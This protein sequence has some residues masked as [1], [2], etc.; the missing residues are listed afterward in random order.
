[1]HL[2][3]CVALVTGASAGI[4]RATA[5]VLAARNVRLVLVGRNPARLH[6]VAEELDATEHVCDFADAAQTAEL[7]ATLG[8]Q[9]P[10][11][12]VVH[13]AGVGL[14]GAAAA[15][16][17][18]DVAR[19]LAVNL[20]APMALTR[21][22]LPGMTGRGS[23]RLVFVT[24]I[25]GRLGVAHESAYAASKAALAAYA[26]SLRVELAG[27]GV[28]VTTVVPGVVDTAF[29]A[30]RGAGYHRTFPRPMPPARVSGAL[31]RGV[32]GDRHRVVVPGW[33]RVPLALH[34][35]APGAY[36][37]LAARWG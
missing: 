32:E 16:A 27:T 15:T 31:V 9:H 3:G 2:D 25:A 21:A 30:R 23:G 6:D 35:L 8:A 4:G 29:F 10:P 22:L 5:R 1:M 28:G 34:D 24:S 18:A 36:A 11:D 37:R 14:A 17:D 19:L 13:N 20:L 7:A 26:D 33:L 12:L